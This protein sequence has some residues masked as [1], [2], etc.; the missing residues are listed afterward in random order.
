MDRA[1]NANRGQAIVEIILG[2]TVVVLI[3]AL[4]THLA[5]NLKKLF[6]HDYLVTAP[7]ASREPDVPMADI[8]KGKL[9]ILK[10][11]SIGQ[12]IHALENQGWQVS[13]K[14]KVKDERIYFLKNGDRQMVFQKNTGVISCTK[15][16]DFN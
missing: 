1:V 11:G 10:D 14:L 4:S 3:I 5:V 6:K 8:F 9:V 16:C 2:M 15:N 12:K 13:R 7:A